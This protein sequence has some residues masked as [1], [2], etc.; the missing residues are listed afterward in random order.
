MITEEEIKALYKPPFRHD[1]GHIWDADGN[2]VA[3]KGEGGSVSRVR[4]WGRL[5]YLPNGAQLQDAAG[6]L[7]AK[8]LT[9]YWGEA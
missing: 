2:L 1:R 5:S 4:G 8:A 7:I 6:D 9:K 3:D